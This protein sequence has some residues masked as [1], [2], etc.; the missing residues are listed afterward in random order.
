MVGNEYMVITD[1]IV[2]FG[3][4]VVSGY[5]VGFGLKIA[6]TSAAIEMKHTGHSFGSRVS[7]VSGGLW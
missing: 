6:R 2:V 1:H 5:M 3:C 4:M 7:R